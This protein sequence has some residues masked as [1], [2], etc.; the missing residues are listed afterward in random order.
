MAQELKDLCELLFPD[1]SEGI[2][3][4]NN[5]CLRSKKCNIGCKFYFL[6]IRQAKKDIEE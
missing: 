4:R 5:I 6:S 2:D 3:I 1:S